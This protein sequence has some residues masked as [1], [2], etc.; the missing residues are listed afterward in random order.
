[1]GLVDLIN[2][3]LE[4][5]QM[6]MTTCTSGSG[7]DAPC[8]KAL[9]DGACCYALECT[10]VTSS[11]TAAQ[12]TAIDLLKAGGFPTTKDAKMNMCAAKAQWSKPIA[13]DPQYKTM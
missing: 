4:I 8:V 13:D 1:M 10:A 6:A 2:N 9:G 7:G 5:N 3:K 11:P 12:Q